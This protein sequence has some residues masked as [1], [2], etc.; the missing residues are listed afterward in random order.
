MEGCEVKALINWWPIAALCLVITLSVYG[1]LWW[2][3]FKL[4]RIKAHLPPAP[5][6]QQ[7]VIATNNIS[8]NV[9]AVT[10]PTAVVGQATG[11]SLSQLVDDQLDYQHDLLC[12]I[13]VQRHLLLALSGVEVRICVSNGAQPWLFISSTN[14]NRPLIIH[15]PKRK[16]H[17]L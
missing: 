4:D 8:T 6:A 14:A 12:Q 5:V 13:E 17:E 15:I 2:L 9:Y 10:T 3:G 16:P 7:D 11:E 1:P